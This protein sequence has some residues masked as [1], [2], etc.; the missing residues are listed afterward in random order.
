MYKIKSGLCLA[1]SLII[2]VFSFSADTEAFDEKS[3]D[4]FFAAGE[5]GVFSEATEAPNSENESPVSDRTEAID[6]SDSESEAMIGEGNLVVGDSVSASFDPAAGSISFYSNGGTLWRDWAERSGISESAIRSV[7]VAEGM[8]YLPE[9]S[10][11]IFSLQYMENIALNNFDTSR[12]TDMSGMFYGNRGLSDIDVTG[13]DTSRVQTMSNMFYGCENLKDIDL[14]GFETSNVRDM[15]GM[16][17]NC[18]SLTE[19]DLSAF[20][21]QS[22]TNMNHMFYF[23]SGLT[24]LEIGGFETKAV[25]N[26]CWM[27]NGCDELRTLDVTGFDTSHVTNMS[28]MFDGCGSLESLDVSNFNTSS[29]GNMSAMFGRCEGLTGLDLSNFD[30]SA[31]RNMCEMFNGCRGLICLDLSGFDTTHVETMNGMFGACTGLQELDISS[32]STSACKDMGGLFS[33]C[34]SLCEINVTGFDTSACR[35]MH[36]MF[37]GCKALSNLDL[38]GF[39]T[40]VCTDMS[41]MFYSCA[42]LETLDL[43]SFDTSECRDMREMFNGCSNLAE[44]NLGSFDTSS[45]TSMFRMFRD[46][47]KLASLNLSSFRTTKVMN[48]SYMFSG[49]ESLERLN[50]SGFSDRGLQSEFGAVDVLDDCVNLTYLNTPVV[51]SAFFTL[52]VEMHDE[53]GNTYNIVPYYDESIVLTRELLTLDTENY[54]IFLSQSSFSYTGDEI[55]PSV[56]IKTK[57][58]K[59]DQLEEGTDYTVSYENNVDLGTAL[60]KVTGIGVFQGEIEVLFSITRA[61]PVLKFAEKEVKKNLTDEPF[62]NELT[63]KTDGAVSF[64]SG[65]DA[66]VTV[67]ESS[68]LVKIMGVG[69]ATITVSAEEENNYSSGTSKYTVTVVE[70]KISIDGFTVKTKNK[71]YEYTGKQLEPSPVVSSGDVTLT[72]GS[73]YV[74]SYEKNVN[75]GV[76]KVIITGKGDYEG[77]A[78]GSFFIINSKELV[79]VY[80]LFN[81]KTGEHFYTT[82]MAERQ[83]LSTG[84]NTNWRTEG[85]AWYAPKKSSE[86]IYRL[87]NPNNGSEHHY[88]NSKKEKDWLVGLGW[89]YEGVAWYSDTNKVVPIYRHYH[90]RQ[91]TGN[92]H[93]TTSKGESD[94]IVKYEGWRYEG[95][96]FY[97]S[98]PGG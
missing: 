28:R 39:I 15:S 3:E 5:E 25:K 59:W 24:R 93:F 96:G 12:V 42:G 68:G 16:F 73:D 27:F 62:V 46:C 29:C 49:C 48:F 74:V 18:E 56:S 47:K 91:R 37:G 71:V 14:S 92:H 23:C 97:V 70:K 55:K 86:P 40:S 53:G 61:K 11:G 88:T 10:S 44:L 30:T 77:K 7:R 76:A 33:D 87:S 2:A 20:D 36:M 82:S 35:N 98:K 81:R 21:T 13:F 1:L 52:P 19:L 8:V 64:S 90:P 57:K 94:H 75:V 51:S 9:N 41:L 85:I 66:V 54:D 83:A 32:F 38:T 60:A 31:C 50:L 43:G 89:R 72:E 26:M 65:D 79:P 22:V 95:V 45:C 80:R 67:N 34:E 17:G 58:G 84:K 63:K 69:T 4:T 78:E 6:A